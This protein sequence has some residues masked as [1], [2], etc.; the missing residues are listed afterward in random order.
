[1]RVLPLAAAAALIGSVLAIAGCN[2]HS[3]S[4]T[5]TPNPVVVGL[6]DTS[7]TIHAHVVAKGFGSIPVSTV[8]FGVFDANDNMLASQTQTVDRNIPASPF[9]F[10][11][12]KDY[13][14][15]INGAAV[16]LSGSRYILVKIIDPSGDVLTQQRLDIVVHALKDLPIPS[17]LT[18][19]SPSPTPRS[20]H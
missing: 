4:M 18:P 8:Q 9:G 5:L 3:L 14:F 15:P 11:I 7:A 6:V 13:T 12:D 19:A 10:V 20:V 16:A 1:M 17:M 2:D